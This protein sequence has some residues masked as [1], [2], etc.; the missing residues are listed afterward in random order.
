M[1]QGARMT[2]ESRVQERYAGGMP[3]FHHVFSQ[4]NNACALVDDVACILAKKG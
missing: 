3:E 1:G 2:E 4:R